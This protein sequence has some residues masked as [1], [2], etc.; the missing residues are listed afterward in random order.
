MGCPKLCPMALFLVFSSSA[1]CI[2]NFAITS[3]LVLVPQTLGEN[4]RW[5][6]AIWT[7]GHMSRFQFYF[8]PCCLCLSSWSCPSSCSWFSRLSHSVALSFP[9]LGGTQHLL[10][11]ATS[12]LPGVGT[13]LYAYSSCMEQ[14]KKSQAGW[15]QRG[16][17][18]SLAGE[19]V[20][21]SMVIHIDERRLTTSTVSSQA[22]LCHLSQ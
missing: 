10:P 9:P 6:L 13:K 15:M 5:A 20:G 7:R 8:D 4:A 12:I 2:S 11:T 16:Q 14:I 22:S 19:A 17:E 1:I 18:C 3:E 21:P